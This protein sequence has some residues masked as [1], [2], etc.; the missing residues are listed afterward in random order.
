MSELP[1]EL[2]YQ[3]SRRQRL[4]P[5]LRLW[6]AWAVVLPLAVVETFLHG[7]WWS[8]LLGLVLVWFFRNLFR[9]LLDVCLRRTVT[10]D[11]RVEENA[12]GVLLGGQRWWLFLDGLTRIDKMTA[13]VWTASPL[14][15]LCRPHS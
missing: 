10:M 1:F 7:R 5:H 9:G 2:R 14:E 6:G 4:V 13:G 15:W 12:L 8:V 11:V 3:L